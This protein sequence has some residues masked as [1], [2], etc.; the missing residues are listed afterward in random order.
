MGNKPNNKNNDHKNK[1][2][3]K[4]RDKNNKSFTLCPLINERKLIIEKRVVSNTISCIG[5]LNYDKK[6]YII[7]GFD[8]GKFEIVDSGNLELVAE[9]NNEINMNEYIRYAGQLLNNNFIIVTGDYIRIYVFYKDSDNSLYIKLIQKFRDKYF[10]SRFS[11]GIIFDK[12]L[13][14]EYDL[15]EVEEERR[16]KKRNLNYSNNNEDD[17]DTSEELIV[18]SDSGIFIYK[19]NNEIKKENQNDNNDDNHIDNDTF[20]IYLYLEKWKTNPYKF[21]KKVTDLDNYD[22]VQVNFKYLAGTIKY[23]LCI[24]SLETYELVTKINVKISEDC[25]SVIF[26]LKE[27]ILC[28]AGDNTISLISIKDF[29]IILMTLIKRR[30]RITEICILP[31]YNILIGMQHKGKVLDDH[32]EYFYQYKCYHKLNPIKKM[33]EYDILEVSSKLLTKNYS[34]ITM[35][36]LNNNRL[37]TVIDLEL[38]QVWE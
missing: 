24:Y 19:R 17:I 12:N 30:Y 20:D 38:I 6:E 1:D 35:R 4:K 32:I 29:E 2:N 26:M 33:M 37:V 27:D 25:D 31:D 8:Y 18:C 10:N 13:Y 23:Y 14:K 15:F 36:C 5:I 16:K 28:V 7:L 11:K 9:E 22:M 21:H 34:N 3:N